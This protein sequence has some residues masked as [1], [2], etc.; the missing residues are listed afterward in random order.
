MRY[1]RFWLAFSCSAVL[2]GCASPDFVNE[3]GFVRPCPPIMGV[4]CPKN[5]IRQGYLPLDEAGAIG[6]MID[7]KSGDITYVSYVRPNSPAEKAGIKVHDVIVA[8][9]GRE[10]TSSRTTQAALF[11]R[12]GKS[13]EIQVK[14]GA[15]IL[16][17]S[18][19][20]APFSSVQQR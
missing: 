13:V 12:A 1:L 3:Q 2:A 10:V 15:S 19:V 9:D 14:R 4:D 11:G 20:R 17:F 16:S 18:V 8:V 7:S 6:I 5:L